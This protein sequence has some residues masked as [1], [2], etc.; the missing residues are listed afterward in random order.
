VNDGRLVV[1]EGIDGCGKS[2][3]LRRL[4]AALRGRGCDLVVTGEP[5]SGPTGR[6]IREM[7]RSGKALEPAEELRWFVEDRREHVRE[8]IAPALEAGRVVITDRYFLSTVAYQGARGLDAAQILADSEAEF[9]VPHLVVLLELDPTR[10]IARIQ[11]R[12]DPVEAVFERA[13]FLE[14]V[15]AQFAALDRGY[16]SRVAADGDVD[17]LAGEIERLVVA[18]LGLAG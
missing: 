11:Q 3:Q 15:A 8:V 4:V 12:G 7:A 6:R 2:T 14:A 13:D 10:A 9:P 1:F 17:T 5:T 16:I 18:R